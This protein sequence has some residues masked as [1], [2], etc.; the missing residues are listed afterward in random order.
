MQTLI[1]PV[2]VTLILAIAIYQFL[3]IQHFKA[4]GKALVVK[5]KP[6]SSHPHSSTKRILVLGDSLAVG[7]GATESKHSIAGR[8]G[9]DHPHASITN[10]AISG[11]RV[12][13]VLQQIAAF[14]EEHFD[15][16]IIQIGGNDVTHFTSLKK[17]AED[18]NK[19]IKQ[20]KIIAPHVL[21]WSS[22]SVGFAPIFI[23]PLSWIYTAETRRI[24]RTLSRIVTAA[25]CTYVNLFVPWSEDIFKTDTKKY[26][27][28]DCFHVA[29]AAYDIWYEKCRPKIQEGLSTFDSPHPN[30]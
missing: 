15:L 19:I 13:D 6:F 22:G 11:A 30:K 28:P 21:V 26:Y 18:M 25:G 7:V 29:D 10:A 20:A 24:Y 27:A 5:T 9:H 8:I 14:H 23:P 17:I 16:I 3:R 1:I 4:I 12:E 2:L